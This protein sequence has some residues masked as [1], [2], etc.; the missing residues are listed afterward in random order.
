M[1]PSIPP[2]L[3]AAIRAG[4]CVAFLGAGFSAAVVPGWGDLLQRAAAACPDPQASERAKKLLAEPSARNLEAAAQILRD[5]DPAG[6]MTTLRREVGE[7]APNPTMERRIG[8]LT[9]IPFSAIL[10]TNFDPLLAG[11]APGAAAF[12]GVLRPRDH[13]WW[14]KRFWQDTRPGPTVVKLHG[15]VAKP[16]GHRPEVVLSRRDYRE[17]LYGTPGYLTFLRS[18]FAVRTVL[19]LGFSFTDAYLNELRSEV[20]ALLGH[21][22]ARAGA[23]PLAYAV[24]NDVSEEEREY[25]R[26][27]EGIEILTYD[28][29][30]PPGHAGFDEIL[31]ALHAET[32]PAHLLGRLLARRR[33]VWLDPQPDNNAD[34][35]RFLRQAA[36]IA[37]TAPCAL[38]QVPSIQ[39]AVAAL[40]GTAAGGGNDTTG[41]GEVDLIITHWGHQRDRDR[42][43]ARCS[44]AERLLADLHAKDLRVPVIV[45]ADGAHASENRSRALRSGAF[46]FTTTWHGLYQSIAR[47]F[48][49]GGEAR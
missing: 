16:A 34:G 35:M 8:W 40:A 25:Y 33:V 26:C 7:V 11:E 3:N 44:T 43:G 27:H 29:E 31:R 49:T 36:A 37:D 4:N 22:G 20:L 23:E 15:D 5:A 14:D 24:I 30:Q 39:A 17:R 19:Y 6:F 28:R 21:D 10:T 13:R 18:L 45:F 42:H 41:E 1:A 46:D 38:E 47:L 48:E 9:G 2:A 12:L 32:N